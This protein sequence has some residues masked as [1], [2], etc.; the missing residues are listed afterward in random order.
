MLDDPERGYPEYEYLGF[1]LL[2]DLRNDWLIDFQIAMYDEFVPNNL[3]LSVQKEIT[4][5]LGLSVGF[6]GNPILINDW[7]TYHKVNDV[8]YIGDVNRGFR[9]RYVFEYGLMV[10][11]AFNFNYKFFSLSAKIN[12]GYSF[13]S[14]FE[15]YVLNKEINSNRLVLYNYRTRSSPAFYFYPEIKLGFDVIRTQNFQYGIQLQSEAYRSTRSIDYTRTRY[16]W[17]ENNS[18]VS[19]I[20]SPGHKITKFQVDLGIYMRF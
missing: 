1:G 20:N 19:D 7:P 4:E 14:R 9:Q 18:V 2:L 6:Y 15:E 8:G 12:A 3:N 13:Y 17:L 5:Y 16:E 10:G 11:P